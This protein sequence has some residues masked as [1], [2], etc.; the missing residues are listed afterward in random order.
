MTKTQKCRRAIDDLSG[1]TTQSNADSGSDEERDQIA[2]SS[3]DSEEGDKT[4]GQEQRLDK[5]KECADDDEA[6][7]DELEDEGPERKR[8][9]VRRGRREWIEL[10]HFDRT[11]MLESEIE[12]NRCCD[13]GDCDRKDEQVQ[14]I[15]VARD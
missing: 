4:E 1:Y 14:F 10:G 2:D 12:F 13:S 5:E 8:R 15:R 11:A 6:G 3:Q 7:E 9:Y